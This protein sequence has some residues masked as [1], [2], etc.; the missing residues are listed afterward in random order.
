ETLNAI[1]VDQSL[2]AVPVVKGITCNM[3]VG[4]LREAMRTSDLKVWTYVDDLDKNVPTNDRDPN[5]DGSYVVGF[6]RVVEADEENANKSASTLKAENH[7]GITLLERLLLELGYFL[8]TGQNLDVANITLCTGSRGA[9]GNVP[10]V[11]FDYGRVRVDWCH[12][13]DSGGILR[14]RSAVS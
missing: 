13:S 3:V 1:K 14:S 10:S 9:R 8:T 6:R 5:R 12:P 11:Y 4:A 2:W 7:K